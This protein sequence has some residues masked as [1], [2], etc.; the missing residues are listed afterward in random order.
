[1]RNLALCLL[2]A[3]AAGVGGC[4]WRI[5]PPVVEDTTSVGSVERAESARARAE[6]MHPACRDSRTDRDRQPEGCDAVARRR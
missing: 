5:T 2:A 1:M 4:T 3:A 6:R